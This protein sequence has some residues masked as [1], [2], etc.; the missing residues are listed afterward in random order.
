[1]RELNEIKGIGPKTKE[2]MLSIWKSVRKIKEASLEE[3]TDKLGSSKGLIV[4]SH[5]NKEEESQE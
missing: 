3:L 1:M 4:F 2:T 5:F